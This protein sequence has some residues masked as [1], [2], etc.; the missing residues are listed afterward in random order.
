[1]GFSFRPTFAALD[2]PTAKIYLLEVY[3]N[4]TYQLST[5]NKTSVKMYCFKEDA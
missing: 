2:T 4:D 3:S 1:M 5:Q